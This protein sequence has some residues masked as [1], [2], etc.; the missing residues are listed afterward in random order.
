MTIVAAAISFIFAAPESSAQAHT[1]GRPV[2]PLSPTLK[3]GDYS[4]HPELSPAA[5]VVILVSLPEQILYVY[6]NGVRIG[7]STVSS[8][9]PG[10]HTPTGVF[11][12]WWGDK[13]WTLI[14]AQAIVAQFLSSFKE[15]PPS[16][17]SGSFDVSAF[18]EKL[19][20][21]AAGMGH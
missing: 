16:Q 13:L 6:R 15:Y 11:T 1:K 2:A 9:K 20:S 14:P 21:G 7:R 18:L 12:G 3:P 5:P 17:K 8:G 19:Q 4:W 10:K